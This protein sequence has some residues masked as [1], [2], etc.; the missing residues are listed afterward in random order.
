MGL[1]DPRLS[2]ASERPF[3]AARMHADTELI[4]EKRRQFLRDQGV[5]RREGSLEPIDDSIG[6]LVGPFRARALG[7]EAGQAGG[8]VG[9]L[10]FVEGRAR[11][12]EALGSLAHRRAVLPDAPQHLV[13][14]LNQVARVEEAVVRPE[15]L[16]LHP[17]RPRVECVVATQRLFLFVP[18][19]LTHPASSFFD[20][21]SVLGTFCR[22]L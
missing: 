16:V 7:Q 10:G 11:E 14:D 2:P 1:V 18:A 13:L 3:D 17:L 8:L 6:E 4:E 12:A 9:G 15:G 5:V 22:P 20:R 19:T 21:S